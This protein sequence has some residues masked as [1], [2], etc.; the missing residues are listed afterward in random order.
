MAEQDMSGGQQTHV[1]VEQE[2]QAFHEE[3]QQAQAAFAGAADVPGSAGAIE[4]EPDPG[5]ETPPPSEGA[6]GDAPEGGAGGEG[7]AEAGGGGG[8]DPL[9]ERQ[10]DEPSTGEM[11]ASELGSE[12]SMKME[13][14]IV[15][16]LSGSEGETTGTE[17]T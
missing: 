16:K 7:G 6:G 4:S 10:Y 11:L 5:A 9:G 2:Q 15:E 1:D 12:P 17:R 14:K 8:Q 13:S 3:A